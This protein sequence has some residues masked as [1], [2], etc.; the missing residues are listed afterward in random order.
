MVVA[1][2]DRAVHADGALNTSVAPRRCPPAGGPKQRSMPLVYELALP[3]PVLLAILNTK[4]RQ[5]AL[6][7]WVREFRSLESMAKAGAHVGVVKG[8]DLDDSTL[9]RC[10]ELRLALPFRFLAVCK[11]ADQARELKKRIANL[12]LSRR[13]PLVVYE[14][15]AYKF[16][17][18]LG[19][20]PRPQ[21]DDSDAGWIFCFYD[22]WLLVWK[23]A[24]S[25]GKWHLWLG[26]EREGETVEEA[27]GRWLVPLQESAD[28]SW[29]PRALAK[30]RSFESDLIAV[31]VKS[32]ASGHSRIW[33]S[34]PNNSHLRDAALNSNTDYWRQ[35]FERERVAKR[36]LVFDNHGTCFKQ[37]HKAE[38]TYDFH[39]SSRFY[40]QTGG[41][42]QVLFSR[43]TNPPATDFSFR[44]FVYGLVESCLC[45]VAVIDER[46]AA[47]VVLSDTHSTEPG[48]EFAANLLGHQKAG[49]FPI[50]RLS[51]EVDDRT[52]K[53]KVAEYSP[54]HSV[55][56][57]GALSNAESGKLGFEYEGLELAGRK[58]AEVALRLLVPRDEQ[59]FSLIEVPEHLEIDFLVI[60]EGALDIF[61]SVFGLKWQETGVT[62]RLLEKVGRVV[63]TS[64]RGRHSNNLEQW[65]PFLEASELNA[66][67]VTNRSKF[68]LC[69]SLF[70]AAGDIS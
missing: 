43:L 31:V 12:G 11:Y 61:G 52:G 60:H 40:Q 46:L 66:A 24:P 5:P 4:S 9:Q 65:T 19:R 10:A 36:A 22:L 8:E 23:G 15:H 51:R 54:M 7:S 6:I 53:R 2:Q 17:S 45:N 37:T 64:G 39:R 16:L 56:L 18:D 28:T 49:V 68:S 38:E 34:D 63:R 14:E 27:W 57:R 42:T 25:G 13:A 30:T 21:I 69:R 20:S 32:R 3:E 1:R 47:E 35:E 44:F 70:G 62:N 41:N 50:F 58:V 55:G 67:V 48:E 26:F 33:T 59:S 29:D